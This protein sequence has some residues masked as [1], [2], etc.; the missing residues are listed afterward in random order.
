[1]GL[2]QD[3]TSNNSG[4]HLVLGLSLTGSPEETITSTTTTTTKKPYSSSS[5]ITSNC[6]AE[7]SLTLGLCSESTN[8][9]QQHLV[10]VT[11]TKVYSEDHVDLSAQTSPHHSAVSSFSSGGCRVVKRERDLSSEEVEAAEIDQRLSSRASDEEEDGT[12]AARKKLRLTKDQ[13]ALLEESFKQHS[14]L[15]PVIIQPI[16]ISL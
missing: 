6:D 14:T 7:P 16:S 4:L 15:N 2:P 8:Y 9:M 1:M 13:S 11:K 10:Q 3:A 12:T 5:T